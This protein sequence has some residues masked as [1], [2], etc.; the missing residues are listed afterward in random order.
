MTEHDLPGPPKVLNICHNAFSCIYVMIINIKKRY[1]LVNDRSLRHIN[2]L[3]VIGIVS[4]MASFYFLYL[5]LYLLFYLQLGLSF[6]LLPW[7][8]YS[9]PIDREEL[10]IQTLEGPFNPSGIYFGYLFYRKILEYEGVKRY[11]WY[12]GPGMDRVCVLIF[13]SI[14]GLVVV[15]LARVV[16]KVIYGMCVVRN[17]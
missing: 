2:L 13:C 14:G 1:S 16:I 7:Y 8:R 5:R 6:M 17:D 4:F 9:T 12:A 10:L 3:S 11:L 15:F